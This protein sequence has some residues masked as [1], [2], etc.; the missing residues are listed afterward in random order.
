M[1]DWDVCFPPFISCQLLFPSLSGEC[2]E[3]HVREW[4]GMRHGGVSNLLS[5]LQFDIGNIL[6]IWPELQSR[7]KI[8]S[9]I[10][11][12]Y[13]LTSSSVMIMML[14][15][16]ECNPTPSLISQFDVIIS[17]DYHSH[18]DE[19]SL[20][21]VGLVTPIT[22]QSQIRRSALNFFRNLVAVT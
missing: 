17:Q 12:K 9:L 8:T 11:H 22:V 2:Q 16:A 15:I 18:Y 4:W 20:K 6:G 5:T 13:L 3:V 10:C 7:Q 14:S 19:E 21:P 1:T